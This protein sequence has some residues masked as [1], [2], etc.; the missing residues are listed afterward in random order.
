MDF[1]LEEVGQFTQLVTE[2][3]TLRKSLFDLYQKIKNCLACVDSGEKQPKTTKPDFDS[4]YWSTG[5]TIFQ[6]DEL[7]REN[8]IFVALIH[9]FQYQVHD[10][11]MNEEDAYEELQEILDR[12][13][14]VIE[15]LKDQ[16]IY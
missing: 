15:P 9:L 2:N 13:Q 1:S 4:W 5:K 10:W 7:R 14:L 3:M 16:L 6:M 12:F 8:L 11:I